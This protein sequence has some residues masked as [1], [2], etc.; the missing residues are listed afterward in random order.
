MS[1]L[2]NAFSFVAARLGSE[3]LLLDAVHSYTRTLSLSDIRKTIRLTVDADQIGHHC[4]SLSHTYISS[5]PPHL[6][7]AYV[8]LVC[9]M[10]VCKT[11]YRCLFCA[12]TVVL[13]TIL[14]MFWHL[15]I[16]TAIMKLSLFGVMRLYAHN[17]IVFVMY[18]S[19]CLS[20][21]V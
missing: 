9:L 2:E 4:L 15:F 18:V 7:I 8:P 1:V 13:L 17:T 3:R 10:F 21:C 19:V 11:L 5:W 16:G 20:V 12:V 14:G 6:L